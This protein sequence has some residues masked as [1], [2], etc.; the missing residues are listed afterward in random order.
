MS[1]D[2][3]AAPA[4]PP[5]TAPVDTSG[6]ASAPTPLRKIPRMDPKTAYTGT[7]AV[8]RMKAY[9]KEVP[10]LRA[11]LLKVI[12]EQE[13]HLK[14]ARAS[15]EEFEETT[16]R[17]EALVTTWEEEQN[18]E[19]RHASPGPTGPPAGPAGGDARG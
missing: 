15:V 6:E 5:T 11:R 4:P 8:D 1:Q 9:L 14:H 17:I 2:N 7:S 10:L 18:A 16:A 13:V 19:R 3:G 12:E